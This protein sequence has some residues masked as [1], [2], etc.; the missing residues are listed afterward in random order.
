MEEPSFDLSKP[1]SQGTSVLPL[2]S[3]LF[4]L[5]AYSD[6]EA[7]L[8]EGCQQFWRADSGV[9]VYRRFRVPEVFAWGCRDITMSLEWQLAALE[10]SMSFKADIPNFLEPWYGIGAV[11]S[12]FGIPYIWNESQ[13]PAIE[14]PFRRA[15][16]ALDRIECSVAESPVGRHILEMIEYFLEET[17]GEVP[18]SI[19]DTQ[20]PL[21]VVS[22]Y[23][24]DMASFSYEMY[25]NPEDVKNLLNA[26]A[27]LESQFI[28]VQEELIGEALARPGHGFASSRVLD[29]LG[30]SDDN[31]LFLSDEAYAEF[32]LG[33]LRNAGGRRA[34]IAFHSC[35]NWSDRADLISRIPRLIM[36]DGAVGPET[37]PDSNP[38]AKLSEVFAGSGV[39][40]HTRIVGGPE[41]VYRHVREL[42]RPG[43]KL[44]VVT[45]C[46]TPEQQEQAYR[47]IHEICQECE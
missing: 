14:P 46:R 21:N 4:D 1:D 28:E 26:V 47:G 2:D 10:R 18:M 23:I 22:S 42:W 37:D 39:T 13:A 33:P 30:F 44:I 5:E 16:D 38:P 36:A 12:A 7:G 17:R 19:S 31:V 41:T 11:A 25:D 24:M 6:Y 27:E 3:Q 34:A 32:A 45:Y 9:A 8:I 43:L 35:G 29:G 20:S 15:S 40:L